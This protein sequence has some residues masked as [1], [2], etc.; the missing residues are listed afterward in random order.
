MFSAEQLKALHH[1]FGWRNPD[2]FLRY[3][4]LVIGGNIISVPN[5]KSYFLSIVNQAY[6]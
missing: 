6:F 1:C 3:K 5:A 2:I 4:T